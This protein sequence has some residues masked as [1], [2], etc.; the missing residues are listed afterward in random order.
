MNKQAALS[1]AISL[2]DEILRVLE[3]S[4]FSTVSELDALRQPLLIEAFSE[5]V[6]QIDQIKANHLQNLNQQVIKKLGEFKQ[7][8]LQQHQKARLASRATSAYTCHQKYEHQTQL[9]S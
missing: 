3:E 5:S 2:T 1:E 4:D 9:T 7:S 8:I 6:E